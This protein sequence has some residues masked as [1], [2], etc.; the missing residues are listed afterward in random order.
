M[1]F[2]WKLAV[3]SFPELQLDSLKFLLGGPLNPQ[4]IRAGTVAFLQ[5]LHLSPLFEF[6][7]DVNFVLSGEGGQNAVVDVLPP[8]LSIIKADHRH[9]LKYH[10]CSGN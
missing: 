10:G 3:G 8:G 9:I 7:F 5:L 4:N 6:R 2:F 1:E